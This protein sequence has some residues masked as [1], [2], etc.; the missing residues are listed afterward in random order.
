MSNVH[1]FLSTENFFS[2]LVESLFRSSFDSVC[3]SSAS[4]APRGDIK[5]GIVSCSPRW[6]LQIIWPSMR[7]HMGSGVPGPVLLLPASIWSIAQK[8]RHM[9]SH[10][11]QSARIVESSWHAAFNLIQFYAAPARLR[12]YL[13]EEIFFWKLG[14]G[15]S[16]ISNYPQR[17]RLSHDIETEKSDDQEEGIIHLIICPGTSLAVIRARS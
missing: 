13:R 3:F 16:M 17:R 7:A 6:N 14:T 9:A 2:S 10:R 15:F 12:L 4:R 1:V 5:R 8:A 11:V